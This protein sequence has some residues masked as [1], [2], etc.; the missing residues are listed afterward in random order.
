MVG[1][2]SY[3]QKIIIDEYAISRCVSKFLKLL[4]FDSKSSR[5]SY[6]NE[7]SCPVLKHS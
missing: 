3:T 6:T 5:F 4:G 7:V 1:W 2:I